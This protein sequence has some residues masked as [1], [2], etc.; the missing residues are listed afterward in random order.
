MTELW[1]RIEQLRQNFY[2]QPCAPN[3]TTDT[4]R[5]VSNKDICY[6]IYPL[7]EQRNVTHL[8]LIILRLLKV[9]LP[10]S[11]PIRSAV[12]NLCDANGRDNYCDFDAIE[13][14]ATFFLGR[15]ILKPCEVFDDILWSMIREFSNGPSYIT[16]HIGHENYTKYL[17]E[18]LLTCAS[19]YAA[20]IPAALPMRD[21]LIVLLVRLERIAILFDVYMHKWTDEKDKKYRSKM[22]GI[23]RHENNRNCA[24]FYVEYAKIECDLGRVESAENVLLATLGQMSPPTQ[25]AEP[26]AVAEY[27]NAAIA[28]IEMLMAEQQLLKC[29]TVLMALAF[30]VVIDNAS[31]DTIEVTEANYL[32]ASKQLQARRDEICAASERWNEATTSAIEYIQPNYAVCAIKAYIYQLLIWRVGMDSILLDISSMLDAF[33][34][35]GTQ[36]TFIRE[37]LYELAANLMRYS[38][39]GGRADNAIVK[40]RSGS[41]M[42]GGACEFPGNMVLLQHLVMNETQPWYHMRSTLFDRKSPIALIFLAIGAQLRYKQYATSLL[43]TN[44]TAPDSLRHIMAI[45]TGLQDLEKAYK[46]RALN[47]F[48]ESTEQT[49]TTRKCSLLWRMYLNSLFESLNGEGRGEIILKGLNECPWNKVTRAI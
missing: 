6:Y 3:E 20:D 21:A 36:A 22:K 44:T 34:G 40:E 27:W 12:F 43:A 38:F 47:I 49:E 29:K 33:K 2:F 24:S 28:Y 41:L 26:Y 8:V 30:G 7:A 32:R 42:K 46:A 15:T 14:L 37:H 10:N 35:A 23:I 13:E 5:I 11:Y 45:S 4:Y 39:D 16:T 1:L 18:L 25:A 17:N 31:M 9:P 19:C 48:R